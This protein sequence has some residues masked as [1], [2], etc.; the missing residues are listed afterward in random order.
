MTFTARGG[1]WVVAQVGLFAGIL[2]AA[3]T[4]G[5]ETVPDR[6]RTI[7]NVLFTIGAVLGIAGALPL[8]LRLSPYP[9]PTAG[10]RLSTGGIFSLVRHPIYGGVILV[11]LGI[12]LRGGSWVAIIGAV[13]LVPF[14][15]LKS[16]H[17]ERLLVERFP[18]YPEY[19]TRVPRRFIPW[20]L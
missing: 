18:A 14:F 9:A 12:G 15:W 6:D 13:V 10:A 1:W 16:S 11:F 8:G 20:L 5:P 19:R 7:G 4:L 3:W 2:W 17:E